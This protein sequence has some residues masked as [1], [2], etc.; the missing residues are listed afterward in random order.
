M[1]R[2]RYFVALFLLARVATAQPQRF[3]W[4]LTNGPGTDVPSILFVNTNGDIIVG[5]DSTIVRTTDHGAHWQAFPNYGF[6]YLR[7]AAA[8]PGGQIILLAATH[9]GNALVRLQ[10]DGSGYTPLALT[11]PERVIA[12]GSGTIFCI[13]GPSSV[14]LPVN[15]PSDTVVARST[16]EGD[17][18]E[19]F[20]GPPAATIRDF[21]DDERNY[22][23]ATNT[24]IYI[25]GD[26]GISWVR[27][28]SIPT[29]DY[30]GVTVG[31]Q[32]RV[33]ANMDGGLFSSSDYGRT[34]QQIENKFDRAYQLAA[35]SDNRA[36]F[37]GGDVLELIDD[38]AS[39]PVNDS[40]NGWQLLAAV[41]SSDSWLA[42]SDPGSFKDGVNVYSSTGGTPWVW[43]PMPAP[44]SYPRSLTSAYSTVYAQV[45]PGEF[46]LDTS[47]LWHRFSQ[48][49]DTL[50]GEDYF[51]NSLFESSPGGGLKR[52]YDTGRSWTNIFPSDPPQM[53]YLAAA[54]SSVLYAGS[55]GIFKSTDSGNTWSETNDAGIT[56]AIKA[57]SV[58]SIGVVY[59]GN[60][61]GLYRSSD[62]GDSWNH[63]T[64]IGTLEIDMIRTN[65]AGTV[66]A[67]GIG[68]EVHRSTDRGTTWQAITIPTSGSVTGIVLSSSGD[69]IASSQQ[70]VYYWP[71]GSDAYYDAS[72]GLR[73]RGVTALTST[74][75][76]T[77]YCATPGA[78]V[79]RASGSLAMLGMSEA[80]PATR[81]SITWPDPAQASV[82]VNIPTQDVWTV[83]ARDPLGREWAVS[84]SRSGLTLHCDVSNLPP[85]VYELMLSSKTT[86]IVS[87]VNILR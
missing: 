41:D 17:S 68:S 19:T 25:S 58:D 81:T 6:W 38:S 52:S 27:C 80:R 47:N 2:Y 64:T 85:G 60:G 53:T 40:L 63:Q 24:G 67:A 66:V 77:L 18:W 72:D 16:D 8:T 55:V 9:L 43:N 62:Q 28:L 13:V 21:A 73:G 32:G 14:D 37:F 42:T 3:H 12:D 87:R 75:D 45:G 57:I 71:A 48:N 49:S 51:D 74:L 69:V 22:Y 50:L 20:R 34:W 46:T 86:V 35:R 31:H 44:L 1:T 10:S 65:A 61:H 29:G 83:Q 84:Y 79:W 7:G 39:T 70:G 15:G 26:S 56:S 30:Y 23:A 76:G 78:G 11:N 36:I 59:A 54:S 33:W 5:A 82:S 4:E